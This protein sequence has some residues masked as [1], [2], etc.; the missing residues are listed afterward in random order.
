[1]SRSRWLAYAMTGALLA[2][3]AAG[4]KAIRLTGSNVALFFR[5]PDPPPAQVVEVAASGARI[6]ATWIGHATVLL[7]LDDKFILTDPI[8]TEYAG[9]L[10]R[11]LVA[12][13]I[14]VERLPPLAAVLVSHRH[15]DHLSPDSLTAIGAKAAKVLVPPDAAGDVPAGPYRVR[16]LARW[17]SDEEDGLRI[18]AVPVDHNGGRFFDRRK[19]PRSFTGFVVEYRGLTV[20]FAGD[21]AFA[22]AL[23]EET[24]ARFPGI[25][26]ALLPIGP[27]EPHGTTHRNHEN[28]SDALEAARLLGAAEMLP[29]HYDTFV[30]SFDAPG[31]CVAALRKAMATGGSYPADRVR[32][33]RIGERLAIPAAG[34]LDAEA[35]A[36]TAAPAVSP[37]AQGAP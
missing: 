28:P 34:T 29:I 15:V 30:H 2:S 21:T 13:A 31:D 6:S 36:R 10:T 7:Q 1:M 35:Q 25:D 18:T 32:V 14:G 16:E 33:L 37:N 5:T 24:A 26:L 27:I 9:S 8:F 17:E 20:Y 23:F 11:R 3:Q 22:P 12:P 4:C 19:H